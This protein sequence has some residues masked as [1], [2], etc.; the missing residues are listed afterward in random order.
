MFGEVNDKN[1]E[2]CFSASR[3]KPGIVSNRREALVECLGGENL[4]PLPSAPYG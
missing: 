2:T 1:S 4:D 3:V